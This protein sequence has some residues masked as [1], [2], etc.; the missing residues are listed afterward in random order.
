MD[1]SNS[2][3]ALFKRDIEREEEA[4][5]QQLKSARFLGGFLGWELAGGGALGALLAGLF[6]S[7]DRDGFWK[8]FFRRPK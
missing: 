8:G 3:L 2:M 7:R 5:R 4:K 1:D 6:C